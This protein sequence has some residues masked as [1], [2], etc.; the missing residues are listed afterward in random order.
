MIRY[1]CQKCGKICKTT[2]DMDRGFQSCPVCKQLTQ[3]LSISRSASIKRS[4]II[5][6][7]TILLGVCVVAVVCA[8]RQDRPAQAVPTAY[9]T[10]APQ[11]DGDG[12]SAGPDGQPVYGS[13]P[14]PADVAAG[15]ESGPTARQGLAN[16]GK[17]YPER[18]W[19]L[20]YY[21]SPN[22]P[23]DVRVPGFGY[24]G[25]MQSE[26]T[27]DVEAAIRPQREVKSEDLVR[28]FGEP[29]DR[30]EKTKKRRY[31][32]IEG[33]TDVWKEV[34][35]DLWQYGPLT[36]AIQDGVVDCMWM[37]V[38]ASGDQEKDE[39][40]RLTAPATFS[41][42]GVLAAPPFTGVALENKTKLHV[43]VVL[44]DAS[45]RMEFHLPPEGQ[46]TGVMLDG[47]RT[48]EMWMVVNDAGRQ[49][50]VVELVNLWN[51]QNWVVAMEQDPTYTYKRQRLSVVR[52]DAGPVGLHKGLGRAL[53]QVRAHVTND[54]V[55]PLCISLRVDGFSI[56]QVVPTDGSADLWAP[57]GKRD[58]LLGSFQ[59]PELS[60]NRD[61]WPGAWRPEDI[62][63]LRSGLSW[64][65]M[66]V[67]G[68]EI[69]RCRLL[70]EDLEACWKLSREDAKSGSGL[71]GPECVE[72]NV[73]RPPR[74]RMLKLFRGECDISIRL[75]NGRNTVIHLSP[76]NYR[77][78]VYLFGAASGSPTPVTIQGPET[79]TLQSNRDGGGVSRSTTEPIS[80]PPRK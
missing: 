47:A 73:I 79:W 9:E 24:R 23:R 30:T 18:H 51:P 68:D 67:T 48:Y 61:K 4:A 54:G 29:D 46:W 5:A 57:P 71:A 52:V 33:K 66:A 36:L 11:P 27:A 40:K 38:R 15:A 31:V 69:W 43:R 64:V 45:F 39:Y 80:A 42:A 75:E 6:G 41:R 12:R 37:R 53:G 65:S 7:A 49:A 26:M 25:T 74:G 22:L 21:V 2:G 58:V 70:K 13:P 14:S 32:G 19:D 3:V 8:R 62:K 72:I 63:P 55:L 77:Y 56:S 35:G 1:R 16:A 76:G 20:L 59:E 34:A 50:G 28:L 78:H 44:R 60:D 17:D 10:D